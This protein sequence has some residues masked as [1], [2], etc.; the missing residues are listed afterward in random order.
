MAKTPLMN[1]P[2]KDPLRARNAYRLVEKILDH[3]KM[4]DQEKA[5]MFGAED[6]TYRTIR[7]QKEIPATEEMLLRVSDMIAIFRI[8]STMYDFD[9][10]TIGRHWIKRKNW[11]APFYGDRP[12][13]HIAKGYLALEE[14][15]RHLEAL[16]A[17]YGGI[18]TG[19]DSVVM[20]GI[21]M[22][23]IVAFNNFALIQNEDADI[24]A[25]MLL[26]VCGV[27]K[28]TSRE[29]AQITKYEISGLKEVAHF[30]SLP[31]ETYLTH[32]RMILMIYYAVLVLNNGNEE[33]AYR[34]MCTSNIMLKNGMT[35]FRVL[36][37]RDLPALYGFLKPL[38]EFMP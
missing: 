32:W 28:L 9:H 31:G 8:L 5:L 30:R 24:L 27:W 7:S 18:A 1:N 29:I 35:P 6:D 17:S 26:R 3:W 15:R 20:G 11:R 25:M 22:G 14:T 2:L 4:S 36:K 12:L 21:M 23:E 34:F 13:D 38:V 19:K 37:N 16:I 10:E 33:V